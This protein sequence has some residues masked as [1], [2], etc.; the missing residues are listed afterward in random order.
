MKVLYA[1]DK[2]TWHIL[3]EKVLSLRGVE[4]VHAYS[5]KEISNLAV[6]EKPDVI[7]LDMTVQNA[8]A[9]DVLPQLL[10]LGIPILVIG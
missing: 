1:D 5:P 3:M 7:I 10:S 4:V 6:A 8:K 9:Y 2:K